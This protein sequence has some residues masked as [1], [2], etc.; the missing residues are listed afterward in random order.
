MSMTSVVL[1]LLEQSDDC[2]KVVAVDGS[3]QFMN[4]NGKKAMQ[5]DDF[6]TF[7]GLPWHTLWPAESQLAVQHSV[8]EAN[9]G[10]AHRF[11]A[12][13]PTAKGDP[14]WW[15]VTVSPLRNRDGDVSA[16][17]STSRDITA[18]IQREDELRTIAAEMRHRLR[19]AHTLGAAIAMAASRDAPEH[20]PFAMRLAE[21][22]SRLA[23][24]QAH[25]FDAGEG[26]TVKSLSDRTFSAFDDGTGRIVCT[27]GEDV[28]LGEQG[29]R[30]LALVLGELATNSAKYGALGR[31]GEV[32]VETSVRD[33][34]VEIVWEERFASDAQ[35]PLAAPSSGQGT[36]LMQR[37]IAL[38]GGQVQGEAR[39]DGY[40]ATISVSLAKVAQ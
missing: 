23:D 17:L 18:R 15:E 21:R 27:G 32:R 1:S 31:G 39:P 8:T 33:D 40:R 5:I 7:A 3:L 19:N 37:M 13:C 12:F 20:R 30:T 34:H 26:M 38:M 35:S 11:E 29:T 24:V 4:C 25:L 36:G 2:I 6:A 14:R 9:E 10:R 22:L 16:I 28:E